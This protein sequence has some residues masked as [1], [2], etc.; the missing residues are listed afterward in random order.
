M[1]LEVRISTCWDVLNSPFASA[2]LDPVP[3]VLSFSKFNTGVF[4]KLRYGCHD[5]IPIRV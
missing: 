4:V 3:L 2:K 5:V 1:Y